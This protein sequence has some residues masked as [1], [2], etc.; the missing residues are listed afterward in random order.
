MAPARFMLLLLCLTPVVTLAGRP[1]LEVP[2]KADEVLIEVPGAGQAL[3]AAKQDPMA[4]I[5]RA[6]AT[7]DV[8]LAD[9]AETLVMRDPTRADSSEGLLLR[10]WAAQHRH[11]FGAANVLLERLLTR[12]PRH[13][14]ALDIRAGIALTTGALRRAAGDCARL[15]LIDAARSVLCTAQ[16][17]RARAR[18]AR[19]AELLQRWLDQ[20]ATESP[21]RAHALLLRAELAAML[22]DPDTEA[23]FLAARGAAPEDLRTLVAYARWLR[24]SGR[25]G[26]ALALLEGRDAPDALLLERALAARAVGDATDAARFTELLEARQRALHAAGLEPELRDAA[27]LALSLRGDARVALA[28]ARG[29]FARQREPEDVLLLERAAAAANAPDAL[30]E[31]AAW[32]EAEGVERAP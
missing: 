15:A 28:L 12:E 7:G 24:Q 31:L 1:A 30:R 9:H 4:L 11:E 13:A 2:A 19:A 32:R 10:A 5:A 27:E 17:E 8:A 23:R 18:P 6:A 16:L 26:D 25:A 22:L 20:G 14:A 3:D 21:L 29:N